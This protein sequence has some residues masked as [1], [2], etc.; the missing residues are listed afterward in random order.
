MVGG[1]KPNLRAGAGHERLRNKGMALVVFAILVA[2]TGGAS[3]FDAM[4][5]VPLRALSA[6]FLVHFLFNITRDMIAS[7]RVL[8]ILFGAYTVI[9]VMQL[10]PLPPWLWNNLPIRD[11]LS[12]LSVGV[13]LSEGWRP[14][15]MTPLRSWNAL[16][17]LVVP[18]AG[19]LA[20]LSVG[21]SSLTLLRLI[22][23]LGFLN[24]LLGL[25]QIAQGQ[26]S[27]FYIYEV[28]NR[29]SP[30]GLMANENHS[31]TF[32]ACSMLIVT[33]L[34]LR[35]RRGPRVAW[36]GV[37]YPTAFVF[38]LFVALVGGSRAGFMAA[39]GATIVS[40]AMLFLMPRTNHHRVSGGAFR[41]WL[42]ERP[43]R[44]MA[45]PIVTVILLAVCFLLLDRA[46]GFRDLVATDS[47]EDLRW[48]LWPVIIEV[49]RGHWLAGT[50]VGSFEQVY[51]IY[52][53]SA[54]LMPRYV[55][56]AHSDWLQVVIEGGVMTGF[57]VVCLVGWVVTSVGAIAMH[58]MRRVDALFWTSLFTLIAA[59]SFIDYPLRT[60]LFQ[61]VSVW[62]LIALS[63]DARDIKTT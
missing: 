24:A 14:L 33:F 62:L 16:G 30:V 58:H 28:T 29:G 15:T 42:D 57:L 35:A 60:P 31:A 6:I 52:E 61:L 5:V 10:L 49:L 39:L 37:V 50:G 51:Y 45:L 22:A 19:L 13:G 48:S 46:P 56:Q 2:V 3:R 44:V 8:V 43:L 38:I 40:L 34:G 11:H 23:G 1:D 27:I 36:E 18:A 59:A 7:Q 20:A 41:R 4:Q 21:G 17:S 55:N 26:G 54:L 9:S 53:P 25:L 32:A 63:R 12:E 47:L